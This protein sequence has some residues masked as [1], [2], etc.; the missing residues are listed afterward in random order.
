MP[1]SRLPLKSFPKT[2]GNIWEYPGKAVDIAGIKG[3]FPGMTLEY[4][5]KP[6]AKRVNA[7]QKNC[8][9]IKHSGTCISLKCI[10]CNYFSMLVYD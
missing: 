1:L 10:S 7:K 8:L 5:R 4:L 6:L 2:D 3:E 9:A